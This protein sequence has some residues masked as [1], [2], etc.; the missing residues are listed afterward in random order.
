MF[1]ASRVKPHQEF[2]A[3]TDAKFRPVNLYTGPDGALYVVDY[4]RQIIEHPEWMGE[5]VIASGELYNDADKGRIYRISAKEAKPAEWT[6][7]LDL[8]DATDEA[9]VMRLA[10]SNGW[11]R[12]NAQRLLIDRKS[13]GSIDPLNAMVRNESSMGRLHALWTLEG[14]GK[15]KSEQ[16]AAALQD[17]EAGIRENAIKL[18]ELHLS[19]F[20]ELENALVDLQSDPDARV[21]F[22]LLCTLG[23]IHSEATDKAQT[24]VVISGY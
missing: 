4:Y 13:K 16:I 21:R 24:A 10:D 5:E 2:L 17:K 19:D 18:A 7:G 6:N 22:Q 12:Q 23:S 11:W 8:A 9:L 3:S 1:T 20:P 15:L 14:L